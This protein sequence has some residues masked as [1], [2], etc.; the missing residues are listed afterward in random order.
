MNNAQQVND[1]KMIFDLDIRGWKISA[2]LFA[3][4]F[5]GLVGCNQSETKT[6]RSIS[7]SDTLTA[8]V[9]TAPP[10]EHDSISSTVADSSR[11]ANPL[12]RIPIL[13]Y[14]LI[15]DTTGRWTRTPEEFRADLQL[16]YDRGYRPVTVSQVVDN[17]MAI[18]RGLSPVVVVFDDA[19]PGQF[20]YVE[21]PDG[22]LQIDPRSAV[23]IWLQFGKQYSDWTNSAVFCMLPGGSSGHAFFGEKG[24][25][26][27]KSAWR[28][29]KVKFLAEQGFELCNHTLWHA[30]LWKYDAAMVQEQIARGDLAIDSAV[31]GYRVRTFALPLGVWPKQREL[32]YQGKWVDPKTGRVQ[33]Y[34]YDAVLEVSGGPTR[35]PEDPEFN[36]RSMTRVQVYGNSLRE[37]LDRLEKDGAGGRYIAR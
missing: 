8:S 22:S 24:I 11:A 34:S 16:L 7:T 10:P 13:E 31:S 14:H 23:G 33:K 19:S 1:L 32:A 25:K 28:L 35:S 17:A 12:G 37:M 21:Q 26:G 5:T 29:Q 2:L 36:G 9:P 18:P 15:G 6:S 20:S 3:S 27:Q 30:N 4:F